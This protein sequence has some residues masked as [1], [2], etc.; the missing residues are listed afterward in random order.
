[1]NYRPEITCGQEENEKRLQVYRF[2]RRLKWVKVGAQQNMGGKVRDRQHEEQPGF[3]WIELMIL[4]E[5]YGG[6]KRPDADIA[7]KRLSGKTRVTAD[8]K[9][10]LERQREA[11]QH[12]TAHM[13]REL[14]AFKNC[15]R[16][17]RGVLRE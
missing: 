17:H 15:E 6:N 7:H 3:S 5:I 11:S 1:M 12:K 4:F 8:V 10:A 9:R 2:L 16:N 13:H 14:E